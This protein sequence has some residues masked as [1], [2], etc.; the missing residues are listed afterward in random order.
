M[1]RIEYSIW[2]N[3]NRYSSTYTNKP[4]IEGNIFSLK[5]RN[6]NGKTTL[7]KI[8]AEAFGASE[9]DND[10]ISDHLKRDISDIADEENKLNYNLTL[11]YP[12]QSTTVNIV[13]NGKDHKYKVNEKPIGK[14]EF[15]R[16]YAVLF[17]VREKIL[18][19]LNRHMRDVESRFDQYLNYIK[20]YESKLGALFEKVTNYEKSEESLNKAR[21]SIKNLKEKLSNYT[22]L[23]GMYSNSLQR[24]GKE[25]INYSYKKKELEY[26]RLEEQLKEI[27]KKLKQTDKNEKGRSI[28]EELLLNKSNDL[29]DE[30]VNS[31]LIFQGLSNTELKDSF[32]KLSGNLKGLSDLN[33]LT[34]EYL[35]SISGF[36]QKAMDF[37]TEQRKGDTSSNRYRDE[38][39]LNFLRRLI[40]IVREFS[41]TDLELPGSGKKLIDLLL[42]L[43]GRY[44]ELLKLHGQYETLDAIFNNSK[45]IIALI[46]Q[47]SVELKR[48]LDQ[49]IQEN[50]PK[51]EKVNPDELNENRKSVEQK[52]DD[53]LIELV[54]M[55]EEY[56]K[57]S[58]DERREFRL[59]SSVAD[60]YNK[61]KNDYEKIVNDI[62]E[63]KKNLEVQEQFEMRF[64]NIQKP[65]T[66]F[67]S[68][69]IISLNKKLLNL[70]T[71]FNIYTTKL[72]DI[73]LTNVERGDIS[74]KSDSEFFSKIGIY[75]AKVVGVVF[76]E[77]KMHRVKQ[78]DF[79]KGVYLLEDG[80][81]IK[82]NTIGSGHS[83]LNAVVARMKNNF[84][85]KKKILLIDEITDMDPGVREFLINEVK[86]QIQS[87]E[88]VLALLT[89]W[90]F[91]GS[92]NELVPIT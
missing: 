55:Q 80:S 25:Y 5:G 9:K 50:K 19:K 60:D 69:D 28:Q 54:K 24:A 1:F 39:E 72:K 47:V 53:L 67:T 92:E 38:Q 34:F 29:R 45:K 35:S 20:V 64:M 58:P 83:S 82:A 14:T 62:K 16:Q 13:Y 33:Y 31:K 21:T 46:G 90:D 42:P 32:T 65:P 7:L 76:H 52:L 44:Q 49:N 27:K 36:F 3:G 30:I 40:E 68:Q 66:K 86:K 18:D 12:D 51:S 8:V 6:D 91:N 59:D 70:K 63:T 84:A 4:E 26:H 22:K 75:L 23:E 43:Q 48:Y 17:E 89:E 15:L 71:K 56:N 10:T 79:Q 78:I 41:T 73:N 87:S 2:L 11:K 57:I 77:H 88:S 81:T 74:N 37:V 61:T 85:G